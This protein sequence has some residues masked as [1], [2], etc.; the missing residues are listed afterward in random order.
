M[1]PPLLLT[2]GMLLPPMD[3]SLPPTDPATT[4]RSQLNLPPSAATPAAFE[5]PYKPATEIRFRWLAQKQEVGQF[6]FQWEPNADVPGISTRWR[7]EYTRQSGHIFAVGRSSLGPDLELVRFEYTQHART[8]PSHVAGTKVTTEVAEGT[9]KTRV[10]QLA[11]EGVVAHEKFLTPGMLT[12]DNYGFDLWILAASRVRAER[13]PGT[14]PFYWPAH[15]Q[16]LE[17]E[18][19]RVERPPEA[20]PGAADWE[21]WTTYHPTFSTELWFSPDGRLQRCRQGDTEIVLATEE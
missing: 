19:A 21:C 9:A 14:V 2:L 7:F 11:G 12:Y 13:G 5:P 6:V 16:V 1:F 4:E 15:N 17:I 10:H 3:G 18:F 20:S 8:G